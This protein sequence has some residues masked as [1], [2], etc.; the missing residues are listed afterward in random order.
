MLDAYARFL[1]RLRRSGHRA[2][3]AFCM[4]KRRKSEM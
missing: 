4:R 1:D 3:S 2:R